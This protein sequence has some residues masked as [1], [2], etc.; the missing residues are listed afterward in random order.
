MDQFETIVGRILLFFPVFLFA[1]TIHEIAHALTAKW[2]GDLTSASQDRL[3]LNPLVHMDLFGT[4]I[5]PLVL[6]TTSPF[7]FGWARPVPVDER[8]FRDKTW[9]VVVAL[10]GPFA[11][12]LL[13]IFGALLLSVALRVMLYGQVEGW[14]AV[15]PELVRG[16]WQVGIVFIFLNVL[17]MIFNLLPVPPLDGSHVVYHFFV[18]GRGHLYQFWDTY[19]RI[20]FIILFML[21][22]LS[23]PVRGI[24]SG[25]MFTVSSLFLWIANPPDPNAFQFN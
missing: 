3:S 11:N 19:T 20:G 4:L 12:L 9:N 16:I 14:W 1:L 21:L 13:A 15:S 23:G 8:N 6:L 17:L 18:R 7:V 10:A 2:G 5:I 25:A 22:I 24:L